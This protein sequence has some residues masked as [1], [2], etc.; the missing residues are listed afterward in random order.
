[1]LTPEERLKRG[2]EAKRK[3]RETHREEARG[4]RETHREEARTW[5]EMH[6]EELQE[7]RHEYYEA[8][9]EERR[10]YRLKY[11]FNLSQEDYDR[12]FV[13]QGGVCA[14]CGSSPNGKVLCV[15]HDHK[16]GEVRALL[17]NKC[18]RGLGYLGDDSNLL[19]RA[20]DYIDQHTDDEEEEGE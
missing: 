6:K 7:K 17:C 15:D 4:Y 12:L 14:I 20:A 10:E 11:K 5:R 19:R 8:H 1:M 3:Y 16:T 18:N 13:S 9:K 2:R